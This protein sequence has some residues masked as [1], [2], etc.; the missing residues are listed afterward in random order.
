MVL[1]VKNELT[2]KKIWPNNNQ[3]ASDINVQMDEGSNLT[4]YESINSHM[5]IKTSQTNLWATILVS[6]VNLNVE[7]A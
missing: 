1:T 5:C 6:I 7:L 2:D 3:F 4:S